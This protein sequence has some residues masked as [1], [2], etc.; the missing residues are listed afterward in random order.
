MVAALLDLVGDLVA[1]HGGGGAGADGVFED[2]RHVVVAGLE[3]LLG[4]EKILLGLA[5][6]TDDD[7]GRKIHVG[8]GGA[9]GSDDLLVSVA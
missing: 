6:E 2:I 8:A 7:I 4:L 9:E 5:G 1:E 3:E